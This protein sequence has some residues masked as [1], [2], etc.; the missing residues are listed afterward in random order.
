MENK[1]I[2]MRPVAEAICK[3]RKGEGGKRQERQLRN[4]LINLSVCD[5]LRNVLAT[6]K[7]YETFLHTL[8]WGEPQI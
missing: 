2:I 3:N 4:Q 1:R 8:Q 7:R 5:Q 6:G